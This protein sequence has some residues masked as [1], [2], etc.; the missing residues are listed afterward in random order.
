M[1]RY[2]EEHE[3][4]ER[5]SLTHDEFELVR[6]RTDCSRLGFAVLL[7]FFQV[8][9][10]FPS[11]RREIPHLGLDYVAS[12][13][14]VPGGAIDDYDLTSRSAKRDPVQISSTNIVQVMSHKNRPNALSRQQL[15]T[16]AH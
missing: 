2:W 14:D 8:E 10:R 11:E 3:L 1:K 16:A 13:L 12:Q 9:A 6:N 5:W 4:A 7:K 15:A